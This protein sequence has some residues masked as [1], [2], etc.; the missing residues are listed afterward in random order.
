MSVKISDQ[1]YL[2]AL[3][4]NVIVTTEQAKKNKIPINGALRNSGLFNTIPVQPRRNFIAAGHNIV[5]TD[6]NKNSAIVIG[7]DRP[8]SLASGYGGKGAMFADT[9]DI[10]AGRLASN[11]NLSDG[12]F[13]GNSFS[14]DA[15]RIYISQ[16]TDVDQNFGIDEGFSGRMEARSTVAAKADTIRVIGREG[17]KTIL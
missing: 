7:S 11:R 14:G 4:E 15:A 16:L 9:I 2:S 1:S 5:L 8:A 17:V 3:K 6:S 10:V 12:E 13:V